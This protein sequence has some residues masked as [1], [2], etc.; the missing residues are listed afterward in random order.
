M[1]IMITIKTFTCG[2]FSCDIE[3]DLG[4]KS[5]Y[6]CFESQWKATELPSYTAASTPMS[7]SLF[8][9]HPF[10][11]HY[12]AYIRK[13]LREERNTCPSFRWTCPPGI[14]GPHRSSGCSPPSRSSCL[15][16]AVQHKWR[17]LAETRRSDM[18]DTHI[19]YAV[20]DLG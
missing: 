20:L 9:H 4:L 2:H 19:K 17:Y 16:G 13:C 14:E 18:Y 7:P 3:V 12:D 1:T 10:A 11:L 8:L 6:P 15:L 5:H